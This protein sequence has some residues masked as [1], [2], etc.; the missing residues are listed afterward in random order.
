MHLQILKV[1]SR[2]Y[3]YKNKLYFTSNFDNLDSNSFFSATNSFNY[4]T[5]NNLS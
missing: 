4:K 3:K 5:L 1:F 2:I